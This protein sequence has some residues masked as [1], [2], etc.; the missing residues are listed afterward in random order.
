M[1][2]LF[3]K[4]NVPTLGAFTMHKHSDLMIGEAALRNFKLFHECSNITVTNT[5][6]HKISKTKS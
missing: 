1:Q 4:Y 3:R 2:V 5:V 6:A